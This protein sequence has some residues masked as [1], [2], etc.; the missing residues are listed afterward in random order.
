MVVRLRFLLVLLGLSANSYGDECTDLTRNFCL[1]DKSSKYQVFCEFDNG[2]THEGYVNCDDKWDGKGIHT[3]PSGHRYEGEY[4]N[5]KRHGYGVFRYPNGGTYKGD[6]HLGNEHGRGEYRHSSGEWTISGIWRNGKKQGLATETHIGGQVKQGRYEND[7]REGV[8]ID[9]LADG[10]VIEVVYRSGTVISKETTKTTA[11]VNREARKKAAKRQRQLLEQER[12]QQAAEWERAKRQAEKNARQLELDEC[13]IE[14]KADSYF[15][16]KIVGKS[17][18]F[19]SCMLDKALDATR[20]LV[21]SAQNV[22]SAIER[23]PSTIEKL[24]YGSGVMKFLN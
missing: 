21:D 22:C 14:F 8:W 11:D 2:Q 20:D 19:V 24:K 3:F 6:W 18:F 12:R 13:K 4:R 23:S 17:E 10:R 7:K 5:G 1:I 15:C 9:N 16:R